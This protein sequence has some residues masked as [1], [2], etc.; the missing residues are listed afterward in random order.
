M[1]PRTAQCLGEAVQ[2]DKMHVVSQVHGRYIA[3]NRVTVP[4][5][6]AQDGVTARRL[7]DVSCQLTGIKPDVL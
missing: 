7:W 2:R 5:R 1:M 4:A 3:R 6:H